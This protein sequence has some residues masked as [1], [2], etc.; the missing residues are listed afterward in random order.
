MWGKNGSG[1]LNKGGRNSGSIYNLQ[2]KVHTGYFQNWKVLSKNNC[3]TV[4]AAK[5]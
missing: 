5:K 3:K 4:V 1:G 2:G